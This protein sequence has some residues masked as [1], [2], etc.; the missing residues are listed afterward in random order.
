M[1][2]AKIK[3]PNK[4]N[5][6]RALLMDESEVQRLNLR[7]MELASF[8]NFNGKQVVKDLLDNRELWEACI[9]DSPSYFDIGISNKFKHGETIN[10]IKLRDMDNYT[11]NR[12]PFEVWNVSTLFILV[13]PEDVKKIREISRSWGAD[14]FSIIPDELA[15]N[16]LGG[17]GGTNKKM[18][19]LLRLWWD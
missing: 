2:G 8:N 16:W 3:K 10:L 5:I 19:K 1:K 18:K 12:L 13:K 14:E 11:K 6:M 7:L 9:M 15:G 17:Y 4:S